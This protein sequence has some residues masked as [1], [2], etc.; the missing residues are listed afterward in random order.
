M[1]E[2]IFRKYKNDETY[3]EIRRLLQS[4]LIAYGQKDFKKL[5]NYE[6]DAL[7]NRQI[8]ASSNYEKMGITEF[9]DKVNCLLPKKLNIVTKEEKIM[10]E[11]LLNVSLKR[12]I[13]NKSND[14]VIDGT[15]DYIGDYTYLVILVENNNSTE[16][17]I[18]ENCGAEI[19][20]GK[21]ECPYCKAVNP[22]KNNKLL[23]ADIIEKEQKNVIKDYYARQQKEAAEA[24]KL[25]LQRLLEDGKRRRGLF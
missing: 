10:I 9:I 20:S 19:E 5:K 17:Q 21:E 6:V 3:R 18:C 24:K 23:I 25:E 13:V 1:D 8:L 2:N 7:I 22:N 15:K 14:A 4:A 12:Y 16:K 11:A